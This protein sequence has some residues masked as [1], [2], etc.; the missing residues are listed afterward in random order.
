[1]LRKGKENIGMKNS[2]SVDNQC[3]KETLYKNFVSFLIREGAFNRKSA[4]LTDKITL[5]VRSP[6]FDGVQ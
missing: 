1:M 3:N 2:Y 4:L 6:I 5:Q